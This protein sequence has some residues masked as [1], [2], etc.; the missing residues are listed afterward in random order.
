MKFKS[1][2]DFKKK[3][4]LEKRLEES[5][6][7]M[8]K[9]PNRVPILVFAHR[10]AP[11][12]DRNKYLVPVDLT[13]SNFLHI[14]RKRIKIDPSESIYTYFDESMVPITAMVSTIYDKHKDEDGFLYCSYCKESTF[15]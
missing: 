12:I 9:Y 5:S 11:E 7:I 14:I 8:D 1:P 10:D 6:K 13:I 2:G 4:P 15:G 3:N